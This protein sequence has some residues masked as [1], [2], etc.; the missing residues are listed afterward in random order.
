M[1]LKSIAMRVFHCR[2]CMHGPDSGWD[3]LDLT[4]PWCCE[5]FKVQHEPAESIQDDFE[6]SGLYFSFLFSPEH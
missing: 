6:K 3:A 5:P 2:G 1:E 4:H